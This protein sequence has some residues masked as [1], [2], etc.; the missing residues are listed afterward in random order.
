MEHVG[1]SLVHD[2]DVILHVPLQR[3][4]RE[5]VL[6]GLEIEKEIRVRLLLQCAA[7]G[8]KRLDR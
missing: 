8:I 4:Q 1:F 3:A 2:G 6:P 5:P 7:R